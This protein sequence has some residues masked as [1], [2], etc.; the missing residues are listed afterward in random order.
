LHYLTVFSHCRFIV[1]WGGGFV[2]GTHCLIIFL[3]E[4]S[5]KRR[6]PGFPGLRY[7]SDPLQSLA[8][9]GTAA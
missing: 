7:R 9:L 1:S 5:A 4:N 8:R 2:N 6:K 3:A